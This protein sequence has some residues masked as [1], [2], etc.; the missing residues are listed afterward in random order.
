MT[1]EYL[2][3]S[4]NGKA[5]YFDP[6]GSHTATHFEDAPGLR[7]ITIEALQ[8]QSLTQPI[9]VIEIDMHRPVGVTDVV[10]IDDTDEIVYAMRKLREDQGWVPFTK[11][12]SS[13]PCS[14]VSLHLKQLDDTKYELVSVWIGELD[15]PPFPQMKNTTADSIPYWRKRAFTWGSQQIVP[16][17][18]RTDYPW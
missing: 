3:T 13:Q 14:L 2:C 1:R 9:E 10:S 7:K 6:T 15:S 16:G 18:E 8:S 11:S 5:I 17:S 12:Q 4:T